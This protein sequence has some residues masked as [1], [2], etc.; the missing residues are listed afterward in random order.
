[1]VLL[2]FSPR[3]P[4]AVRSSLEY[5]N[6]HVGKVQSQGL[7]PTKNF[8]DSFSA[9][10]RSVITPLSSLASGTTASAYGENTT[11]CATRELLGIFS[12][13]FPTSSSGGKQLAISNTLEVPQMGEFLFHQ[14]QTGESENIDSWWA[15]RSH[16]HLMFHSWAFSLY[17]IQVISWELV[18]RNIIA[19]DKK[20]ALIPKCPSCNSLVG[21]SLGIIEHL[22]LLN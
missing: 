12:Y 15:R 6:F 11:Y 10:M 21:A 8:R 20:C 3:S 5:W 17:Q 4:T 19:F 14:P 1:M 16:S 18:C 13:F 7:E 22:I 9:I 2:P